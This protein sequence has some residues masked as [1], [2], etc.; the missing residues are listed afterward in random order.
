MKEVPACVFH[1]GPQPLCAATWPFVVSPVRILVLQCCRAQPIGAIGTACSSQWLYRRAIAS[2][3]CLSRE[4]LVVY[5]P[6]TRGK[7][8]PAARRAHLG[9]MTSCRQGGPVSL[10]Q[11][12]LPCLV[13]QQKIQR[14]WRCGSRAARACLRRV[15]P[16]SPAPGASK[17]S[18]SSPSGAKPSSERQVSQVRFS[19][20]TR[21]PHFEQIICFMLSYQVFIPLLR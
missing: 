19:N 14:R 3:A 2:S 9:A 20:K 13:G 1:Q 12:G 7:P 4:A 5:W 18:M 11:R 17:A 15:C 21:L 16:M 8:A 10:A 6:P